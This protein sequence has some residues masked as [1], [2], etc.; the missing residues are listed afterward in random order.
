MPIN[1]M[2]ETS[3]VRLRF[4]DRIDEE[5]RERLV[6]RT[7]SN[8]K[9]EAADEALYNASATIVGLQSKPLKTIIRADEK[10]LVE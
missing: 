4:V 10:E 5:G 1:I 7:Y 9:P 8:V 6:T 2:N 3:R